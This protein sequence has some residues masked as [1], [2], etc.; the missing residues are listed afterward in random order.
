MNSNPQVSD[1]LLEWQERLAQGRPASVEELC[2]DCPHL[3]EEVRS[4]V[5]AP[6]T[7]DPVRLTP[8]M[9]GGGAT[10]IHEPAVG[11]GTPPHRPFPSTG[12]P[13]VAGYEILGELGRGGM[14]VVYK[15]RQDGPEPPGRPQDD[16]R[17]RPRPASSELAPLPRRGRGRRPAPAPQHRAGLRGRR[18]RRPALLLAGVRRRRQPRPTAR[19]QAP[20]PPRGRRGWCESLAAGDAGRPR[21]RRHPP[22]PQARQHPAP[23]PGRPGW[24]RHRPKITDFGLAKQLDDDSGQTRTGRGHGH[25][26]LHGPRAGRRR[27]RTTIGPP[28]TSTPW[29]RSCTSC[30]PAGRRS[31]GATPCWRRS[32]RCRTHEPVPPA[33]LQPDVPRDLETICLK[34][35]QKEPGRRYAG[36]AELADD[37]RRFLDGE[38]ILARPVG[39]AERAARGAKRP[40]VAALAAAVLLL[41]VAV[42]GVAASATRRR[43]GAGERGTAAQE[44][45]RLRGLAEGESEL[46]LASKRKATAEAARRRRLLY[47]ADVRLAGQLLEIEQGSARRAEELLDDWASPTAEGDPRVA[48]RYLWGLLHDAPGVLFAG[49]GLEMR[50]R[51]ACRRALATI[52][53]R[54]AVRCWKPSNGKMNPQGPTRPAGR[55]VASALSASGNV[56]AVLT[57]GG[58]LRLLDPATMKVRHDVHADGDAVWL[59]PDGSRAVVAARP[60]ARRGRGTRPRANS[61]ARS[62]KRRA[63]W[64]PWSPWPPTASP[65]PRERDRATPSPRWPS[66][67]RRAGEAPSARTTP[68]SRWPS[69]PTARCW[70]AAIS[71]AESSCGTS[72]RGRKSAGSRPTSARPIVWPSP[73]TASGSP[74]AATRA[75]SRSSTSQRAARCF[76]Q[77]GHTSAVTFVS[78]SPDGNRLASGTREGAVRVWDT[79]QPPG[80]RRLQDGGPRVTQLAFSP[81]GKWLAAA[82]RGA[83]QAVDRRRGAVRQGARGPGPAGAWCAR[84]RPGQQDAG[85]GGRQRHVHLWDVEKARRVRTLEDERGL[86][87][88]PFPGVSSLAFSPDG[89]SLGV[90]HG[91]LNINGKKYAQ[92]ARIWDVRRG[93]GRPHLAPRPHGFFP[94]LLPQRRHFRERLRRREGADLG[95]PRLGAGPDVGRPRACHLCRLLAGGR[96]RRRRLLRRRDTRLGGSFGR[97][98]VAPERARPPRGRAGLHARRQD[99]RLGGRRPH[100]AAVAPGQRPGPAGPAWPP[101]PALRAGHRA[102]RQHHRLGRPGGSG[103]TLAGAFARAGRRGPGPRRR[104]RARSRRTGR[105]R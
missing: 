62:R 89:N 70:R 31:S 103:P 83:G 101:R 93:E 28:P 87:D 76:A 2:K 25:A 68:S 69:P 10:E 15:A 8:L 21:A 71:G 3:L 35:L 33:R 77:E 92:V 61:T 32:S 37:L 85:R 1:V 42:V 94:R 38:P 82:H 84:V 66:W 18:A 9:A 41:L 36:A 105:Q 46:A 75:A 27:R 52:D 90:G 20:R 96:S 13:A 22:R 55:L 86:R 44:A 54:H 74:A 81:D 17:R 7:L 11:P 14:G 16:P 72:R 99:P 45:E 56:V 58:R 73:R 23:S 97:E 30:S 63:A 78:L 95:R 88:N 100:G 19:R 29:G 91:S 67:G 51:L 5:Q 47:A 4:R 98:A 53:S 43:A 34:C 57:K 64:A 6:Q 49:E 79:T 60:T 65:W 104:S 80:P 24:R 26:Q 40:A 48:W 39:P 102:G 50:G 12:L 59:T